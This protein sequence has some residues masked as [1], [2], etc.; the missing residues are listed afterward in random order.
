MEGAKR[1]AWLQP[2]ERWDRFNRLTLRL[3]SRARWEIDSPDGLTR[4]FQAVGASRG[5]GASTRLDAS[6]G[7]RELMRLTKIRDRAGNSIGLLYDDN[8]NLDTIVDAVGR[9][10]RLETDR[11]GRLQRLLVPHPVANGSVEHARYVYSAEG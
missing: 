3:C 8:A 5:A 7:R 11:A 9:Q 6:P 4:E 1:P 2:N 10:I